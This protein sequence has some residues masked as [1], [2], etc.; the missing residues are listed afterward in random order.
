MLLKSGDARWWYHPTEAESV[1]VAV[2]PFAPGMF[3]D[4]DIE[5][6][7]EQTFASNASIRKFGVGLG[8][9]IFTVGLFTRFLV[10]LNSS[11]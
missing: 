11:R 1:D 6:I 2:T 7:P 3:G 10:L 5:Y 4:Y 8:D 9:E